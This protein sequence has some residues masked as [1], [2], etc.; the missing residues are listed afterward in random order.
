VWGLPGKS[1]ISLVIEPRDQ[2]LGHT[3]TASQ[4]RKNDLLFHLARCL[5]GAL[6]HTPRTLRPALGW[7]LGHLAWLGWVSGRRAITQGLRLAGV[8]D[9]TPRAVFVGLGGIVADILALTRP[10][11]AES[12]GWALDRTSQSCLDEAIA[13]GRGIVFVTGHLGGWERMA[14]ALA[15]RGYPI[16]TLARASYDARFHTLYDRVRR[17]RGVEI[18]YRGGP[19]DEFA[20]TRAI[21]RAVRQ[22]RV[23]GF[24]MDLVGRGI[25]TASVP[26]LGARR[27]LPVGPATIAVRTGAVVLVGTPCR[28]I[29]EGASILLERVPDVADGGRPWTAESLTEELARRL[30][31]RIRALPNEWP[32]ML[33]AEAGPGP[34][35]SGAT[36]EISCATNSTQPSP[37]PT[38]VAIS[39]RSR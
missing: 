9:T 12:G 14:G 11:P 28:P 32:W 30:E 23:V 21:V 19:G 22:G 16:T 38:P 1:L 15:E 6:A 7:T 8:H 29:H 20:T 33:V 39:A 10:G 26:F 37:D 18:I 2:R 17:A 5:V 31:A 24:P 34:L 25:R 27:P 35:L 3:W 13:T 36:Q 4:R